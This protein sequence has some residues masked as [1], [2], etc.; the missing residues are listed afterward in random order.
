VLNIFARLPTHTR[1]R[2]AAVCRAWRAELADGSLWTRLDLRGSAAAAQNIYDRTLSMVTDAL[3]RTAAARAAPFG[4]LQSL[5]VRGR[6]FITHAAL[7][8]VV[9]DN[10]A[11]LRELHWDRASWHHSSL[12]EIEALLRAAPAL[13]ELD[14]CERVCCT[15]AEA[16]RLL[17][18]E[19]PFGSVR[20]RKLV[21][22]FLR[23]AVSDD[24][25][26]CSGSET[27]SEDDEASDDGSESES[28]SGESGSESES[29][30]GSGSEDDE[31]VPLA[32]AALLADVAAARTTP[33]SLA[34]IHCPLGGA[35]GA[36][37]AVVDAA[38]FHG[39]SALSLEACG[40][41]PASA[42]AIARLLRGGS[43]R[44]LSIENHAHVFDAPA[45]ALV[46]AALRAN[47]TLTSLTLGVELWDDLAAATALLGALRAHPSLRCLNLRFNEAGP[48][49]AEAGAALAAIIAADVPALRTLDCSSCALGDEG[50]RA[51]AEALPANTHLHTLKAML[52]G[53]T[54]AFAATHL[55]AA[56][57]ANVSLRHLDVGELGAVAGTN[58]AKNFVSER[59]WW[60]WPRW[61]RESEGRDEQEQDD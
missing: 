54:A 4:G 5:D 48:H 20:T 33:C 38:L 2:L 21:V 24:D 50:M 59:P 47:T 1:L 14:V 30:S 19:P 60:S 36:L 29:G 16:R 13:R 32:L 57:R 44:E 34:L 3:L 28:G 42:P 61:A 6:S 49:A 10:A 55:L 37:N 22:D 27:E 11:S 46:A 35:P 15:P 58:L 7:L 8:A 51:I 39:F 40:L 52:N 53:T 12:E 43:L 45:A 26:G 56:V 25:S 9:T 23:N 17:Q 18:R 41:A 31:A